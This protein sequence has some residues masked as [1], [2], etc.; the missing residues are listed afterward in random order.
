MHQ[1]LHATENSKLRERSGGVN[2]DSKLVALLYILMRDHI[3]P[4]VME[5]VVRV[6]V[7]E[8]STLYTNGFLA[9]YAKD[10]AER[11]K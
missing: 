3:T 2:S 4:G 11:L 8:A 5:K 1:S 9:N 10:L 6:H 7:S